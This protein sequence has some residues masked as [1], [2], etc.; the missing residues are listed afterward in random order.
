MKKRLQLYGLWKAERKTVLGGKFQ[1][2]DKT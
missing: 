1:R 2:K